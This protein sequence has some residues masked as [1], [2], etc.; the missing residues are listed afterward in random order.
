MVIERNDT[1]LAAK[2]KFRK[3]TVS[4]RGKTAHPWNPGELVT[5]LCWAER[6]R[7]KLNT[8]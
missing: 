8:K 4:E 3:T 5:E 6:R 7:V 1:L 2:G